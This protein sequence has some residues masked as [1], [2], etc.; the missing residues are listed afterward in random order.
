MDLHVI[1]PGRAPV[2]VMQVVGGKVVLPP[3][4]A[5]APA[6]PAK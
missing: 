4:P 6:Q 5:A 3:A 2:L 1:V